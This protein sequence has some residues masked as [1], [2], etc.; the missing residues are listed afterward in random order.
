MLTQVMWR[1]GCALLGFALGVT[2]YVIAFWNDGDGTLGLLIGFGLFLG[3][4]PGL[5]FGSLAGEVLARV[6]KKPE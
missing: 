3:G 6:L 4:I 1:I 5:L 2:A